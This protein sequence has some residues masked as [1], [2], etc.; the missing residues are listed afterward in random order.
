MHLSAHPDLDC[1]YLSIRLNFSEFYKKPGKAWPS[2]FFVV[3]YTLLVSSLIIPVSVMALRFSY[4]YNEKLR[5]SLCNYIFTVNYSTACTL[6]LISNI[7][8]IITEPR[9]TVQYASNC[10]CACWWYMK[11]VVFMQ[12]QKWWWTRMDR[13]VYVKIV[14]CRV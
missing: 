1:K 14:K 11:S 13:Q 9:I 6:E 7:C 4:M 3:L 5:P 12:C 2:V 10:V 8:T